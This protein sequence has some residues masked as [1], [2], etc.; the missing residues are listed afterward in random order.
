LTL[1]IRG[2]LTLWYTAVLS[3][4]L[5]A[6]LAAFYLL[7]SRRLRSQFDAEL[8]RAGSLVARLMAIELDEAPALPEAAR[9]ALEDIEMPGR[10]LAVFDAEGRLLAGGWPDG[11]VGRATELEAEGRL[12]ATVSTPSGAERRYQGRHRHGET[13]FQV[14]V[15]ESLAALDRDLS[16]V[17][18]ALLGSFVFALVLAAGGGYW[19]SRAALRPVALLAGQAE[20]ITDRTPGR[21]LVPP[22]PE[23]ELGALAR[24]FNDLLARLEA[25]LAQQRQFMADASHEL[26]TPVSVARTAIEVTLGRGG[27]PAHEY[28]ESLGIVAEQMR[29]L[30]RIVD[31]M[32]TLARADADGLPLARAPLYLD[33]LVA[34]CVKEARLLADAKGVGLEWGGPDDVEVDAD[35]PRLRQALMNVLDNAIRHTL[36]GGKVSVTVECRPE[37]V[38]VAVSD[39]GPGIPAGDEERVFERFVRLHPSRQEGEG[40]GLGLP[41][42]RSIV[43]AHGGTLVL[44]RTDASGSR[45]VVRLP[46]G[47][48]A[49]S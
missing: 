13:I 43:E 37:A 16:G 29:R 8:F 1:S 9:D 6:T 34:D 26:R 35:E 47:S 3:L 15:T 24:A 46:R 7:H 30:T 19:I 17:R 48:S 41:I 12:A 14:G 32:F 11:K 2:R 45:F 20:G 42:A 36:A 27:R 38:S 39:G 31:D 18:Q 5:A 49:S 21:R 22:H 40:A 4:A 23:D 10:S 44:E 25:A 33:E 28:Q